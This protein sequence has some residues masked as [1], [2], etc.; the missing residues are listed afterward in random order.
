[1][2]MDTEVRQLKQSFGKAVLWILFLLVVATGTTYAWF[3]LSGLAS[4]NVTPMGGSISNGDASL[5]ISAS[6][7]GPFDK[8]CELVLDRSV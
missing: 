1:M 5:L 4:T 8:N 2:D 3:T 7:L 6:R